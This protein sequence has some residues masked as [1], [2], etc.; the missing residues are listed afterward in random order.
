[1]FIVWGRKITREALGYVADFCPV[2]RAQQTFELVAVRS[3]NHIYYI[4]LG[5][6]QLLGYERQCCDCGTP[7]K[8]NP[9]AYASVLQNRLPLD[10]V[11]RQTFPKLDEATRSELALMER[12][13]S[14]HERL[15]SSERHALIKTTFV[16]VSSR[17]ERH[18][19]RPRIDKG[20][21]VALAA[22][23]VALMIVGPLVEK[24]VFPDPPGTVFG[25]SLLFGIGI[26]IWQVIE[27][28]PRFIKGEIVPVL[29]RSLSP[30]QPT[31]DE[32]E[33]V[34]AELKQT[35]RKIGRKVSVTDLVERMEMTVSQS[36]GKDK[37]PAL[38]QAAGTPTAHM[39]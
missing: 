25:A 22:A 6:G 17:V 9:A 4:G 37:A 28:G 1:M 31:A 13:R 15:S 35:K 20:V 19:A 12:I 3:T 33:R 8:A 7:F 26:V 30:I 2:C 10:E 27:S 23:A 34:L 16:F 11:K 18:F 38:Q 5:T 39:N 14:G 29:A 36:S 21:G 24:F 32:I